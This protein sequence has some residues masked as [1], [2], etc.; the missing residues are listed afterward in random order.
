MSD[1][2]LFFPETLTLMGALLTFAVSMLGGSPRTTWMLALLTTLVIVAA[3]VMALGA[4]GEAFAP[5][6]YHIDAF[7]QPIKLGLAVG[8]TLVVLLSRDLESVRPFGR[9]DLPTFFLLSTAG[10]MMLT[11]ATELLTFYVALELSAYGLYVSVGLARAE[12]AGSEAAIKYVLFGAASSA[13]SLYGISL[14]FGATGTTYLADI[15]A[16]AGAMHGPLIL[17]I[18]VL[19]LL[20]GLLFKLAL[21]PFHFWAPDAYQSAPH[22]VVTLVATVSKLAA[23]AIIVRICSLVF[24]APGALLDVFLIASV[25]SMSVGNLAAMVQRDLKRLLAYSTVAHAGYVFVGMS[26][27]TVTG[28][29]SALFYGFLYL[30]VSMA[31]F[32]VVCTLGNDGHNPTKET[33]SGL[34]RRSPALALVLL[35]AVFGL[36]GIPPTAGFISKWMVFSA[37]LERGNFALV[38]VAAINSTIALYYYLQLVREAYLN[39]PTTDEPIGVPWPYAL[40][41]VVS[42]ILVIVAGVYPEPLWNLCTRAAEA[43]LTLH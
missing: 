20:S 30:A 3:S 7:S 28:F 17:A 29:A 34:Y 25:V 41:G 10:M 5:G 8:L 38:L 24:S 11:S 2:M 15:G 35:V 6:I 9:V 21:F 33:L 32:T 14:V 13:V 37:A 12:R 23:I 40:A 27:F 19:L 31:A 39:E 18:G 36:A 42:C 26:A 1:V 4:V 16:P 43:V 22:P